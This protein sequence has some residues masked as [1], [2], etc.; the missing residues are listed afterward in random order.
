[1]RKREKVGGERRGSNPLPSLI[2][3]ACSTKGEKKDGADFF[4]DRS[5]EGR[6]RKKKKEG[7]K[8]L[9]FLPHYITIDPPAVEEKGEVHHFYRWGGGGGGVSL[10]ERVETK[11]REKKGKRDYW[12]R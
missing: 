6:E 3:I 12:L 1:M 7:K 4:C 5:R 11:E 10:R 9:S 2:T 8:K